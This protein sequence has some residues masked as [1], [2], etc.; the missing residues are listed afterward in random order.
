MCLEEIEEFV[1]TIAVG[2]ATRWAGPSPTRH[3]APH[4]SRLERQRG[5]LMYLIWLPLHQ[6]DQCSIQTWPCSW[7]TMTRTGGRGATRGGVQHEVSQA[8]EQERDRNSVNDSFGE[9]MSRDF[10]NA[11]MK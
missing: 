1:Q 4:T 7:I 2:T 11:A 10:L 6:K 3:S 8:H 5:T 9:G